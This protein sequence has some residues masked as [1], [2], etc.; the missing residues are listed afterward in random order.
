MQLRRLRQGVILSSVLF[1]GLA[2][3]AGAT[4]EDHIKGVIFARAIDGTLTVRANDASTLTLILKDFTEVKRVDGMRELTLNSSSLIPGLRVHASGEYQGTNQFVAEK[5]TFSRS[6]MKLA[7]AIRGGVDPTDLR[8]LDNQRR[9]AENAKIIEQQQQ[10]LARQAGEIAANK[11]QINAN[12]QKIL[13]TSGALDVTN[14]RIANL[15]DYKVISTVTVYFRNDQARLESQYKTQLQQL[16][17]QARTVPGYMIQI[18]GFA[19]AVGSN[20]RNQRLSLQRAQIVTAE[21]QQSGIPPT[22]IVVPAAMGVTNQVAT[23]KTAK[24]QAENRRTVVT[25]LQ[26]KGLTGQ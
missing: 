7:L 26:N 25:L 3:P 23:N 12:E 4:A 21:L 13:A 8:S 18:Q 22:N 1:A 20:D 5:V 10:T 19:S 14:A 15:D 24:G 2:W 17:A 9:I 6:D 11:D 16:A